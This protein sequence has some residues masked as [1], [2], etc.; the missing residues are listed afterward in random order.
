MDDRPFSR[1][2]SCL[3]QVYI[4]MHSFLPSEL[5]VVQFF[6]ERLNMVSRLNPHMNVNGGI[7][8][9]TPF[10]EGRGR[11]EELGIFTQ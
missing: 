6:L 5:W 8:S 11:G 1:F 3:K 9:P 4:N 2:N 10:G 7:T